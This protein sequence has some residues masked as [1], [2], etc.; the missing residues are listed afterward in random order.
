VD[1]LMSADP[2]IVPQ[3]RLLERIRFI[4]AIEM[5]LFGAKSM[6]PAR[7]SRRP[8]ARSRSA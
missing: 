2:R 5:G 1:G 3:A 4:E 8:T 6:H 7:W